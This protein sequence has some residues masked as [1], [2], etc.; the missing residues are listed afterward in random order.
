MTIVCLEHMPKMFSG[1]CVYFLVV[2]PIKHIGP[3][4]AND[5]DMMLLMLR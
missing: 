1:L 2:R 3:C 5:N 4:H